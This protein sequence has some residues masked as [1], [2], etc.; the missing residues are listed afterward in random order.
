MG[1]RLLDAH[2]ALLARG[3]EVRRARDDLARRL[4]DAG[5]RDPPVAADRQEPLIE[6]RAHELGVDDVVVADIGAEVERRI[7]CAAAA[8]HLQE[9]APGA[10]FLTADMR[11][12]SPVAR[13]PRTSGNASHYCPCETRD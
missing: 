5:A 13:P 10:L 2:Q 9:V 7:G 1:Q 3:M 11:V 12:A 4:I 8:V 6:E